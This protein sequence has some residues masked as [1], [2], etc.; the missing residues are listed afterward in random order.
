MFKQ[1]K[2]NPP[3]VSNSLFN[4]TVFVYVMRPPRST[5][6]VTEQVKLYEH[7]KTPTKRMKSGYSIGVRLQRRRNNGRN[8]GAI[9]RTG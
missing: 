2:K 7:F 1:N 3:H 6:T 4:N 5:S 9:A 8:T